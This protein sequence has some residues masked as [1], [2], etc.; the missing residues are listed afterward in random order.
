MPSI[1]ASRITS[2]TGQ[3]SF[4]TST[5]ALGSG[6]PVGAPVN[7]ATQTAGG[8]TG[9]NTTLTLISPQAGTQLFDSLAQSTTADN[10]IT[11]TLRSL[12]PG[13]N[14]N[15]SE[16]G[17]LITIGTTLLAGPTGPTGPSGGPTG[18]TGAT[19][20]T[21]PAINTSNVSIT[22]GSITLT[23]YLTQAVADNVS[24]HAGGGQGAAT[25]LTAQINRIT[26]V[27]TAGDSVKLPASAV[28]LE[29]VA[30]N[31]G[32]NPMQVYGAGS[33]T[34]NGVASATGVSQ[35]PNSVVTY[36]CTTSGA[37]LANGIGTG[38][39]AGLPTASCQNNIAAAG[40]TQGNATA[41]VAAI[42]RVTTVAANSGV[43][44][45]ASAG[46]LSIAVVNATTT[47]GLNVYP[48]DT[49]GDTING[50][51]ANAPFSVPPGKTAT[52]VCAASGQWHTVLGA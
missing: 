34:I 16:S 48:A 2:G 45:P 38:Y 42:N 52:F 33:D 25:A 49:S 7:V 14:I 18:P 41:L 6:A 29:I 28:G 51:A 27:A 44:L 46:G 4:S 10:N 32:A 23:G 19:G 11:L 1:G 31:N 15:I 40:T 47:N 20:P 30:A 8:T 5:T 35:M 26:T 43:A 9:Y 36:V 13:P 3:I 21:G 17:G 22:G 39:A 37:W 24:A 12:A 50:Q